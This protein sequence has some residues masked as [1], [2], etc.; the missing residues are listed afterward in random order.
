MSDYPS[1]PPPAYPP[2]PQPDIPANPTNT[3]AIISLVAGILGWSLLPTLGS[4]VAIITGHMAK[5]EIRGSGGRMSGDGMATAGLILGYANIAVVVLGLCLVFV[6]LPIL[7]IG[8]AALCFPFM[9][10]VN[11]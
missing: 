2:A 9:N 1:N 4:I 8:S 7:G 6:I 10:G 5:N 11:P 3:L